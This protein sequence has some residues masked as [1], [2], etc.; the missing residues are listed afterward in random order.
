MNVRRLKRSRQRG[1]GKRRRAEPRAGGGR[2]PRG[3]LQ[4]HDPNPAQRDTRSGTCHRHQSARRAPSCRSAAR[5]RCSCPAVRLRCASL[6]VTGESQTA[7]EAALTTAGLALGTVTQQV[8]TTQTP[9][10][11]LSQSPPAGA[12]VRAGTRREPDGGAGVRRSGCAEGRRA[13]R[14][15]GRGRAGRGGVHPESRIGDDDRSEPG[16]PGPETEPGGGPARAQGRDG[17]AH[18]G[19]LGPQTTPTTPTTT[20]TTPTTPHRHHRGAPGGRR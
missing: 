5:L 1:P 15:P 17:D 4:A 3:G 9:G 16:G 6:I 2:T 7:A 18:G 10:T 14:G 11:V 19:V 20:P 12:S 13:E 8:S